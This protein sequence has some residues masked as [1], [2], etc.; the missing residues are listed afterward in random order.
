MD[1]DHDRGPH[2]ATPMFKVFRERLF[3]FRN[4]NP[5]GLIRLSFSAFHLHVNNLACWFPALFDEYETIHT[6]VIE[7]IHWLPAALP[8]SENNSLDCV[9]TNLA[10]S[11]ILKCH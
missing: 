2:N 5:T 7:R 9:D 3:I 6:I 1:V 4:R 10:C 11:L 8:V